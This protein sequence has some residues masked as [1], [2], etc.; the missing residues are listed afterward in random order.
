MNNKITAAYEYIRSVTDFKPQAGIILGS[1]LGEYADTL[2]NPVVIPY[3]SIP[4]FPVSTVHGHSGR[5]ILGTAFGKKIIAMQGRVHYYEGYSMNEL[6]IPVRLINMLGAKSVII[7]NAAGGVNINLPV[8][9]LMLI[10][11]HINHSGSNPLTGENLENFG[12]RF[13]DMSNIYTKSLREQ[14]K[15]SAKNVGLSLYEG[16]YMMFNGPSYE[17]PA[18]IRMAR[19]FGADA[20]GMSTVPEAISAAHANMNVI[21]ISCISNHAAGVTDTT[22]THKD[23]IDVTSRTKSDFI[24]L[25]NLILN[26]II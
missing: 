10:S 12:T 15:A 26:D 11:D 3:E 24:K 17:T 25:L 14:I 16:V 13:P 22:L 7:T 9:S 5:F 19:L 23:V 1:G 18:E 6:A 2:E 20:V 4:H 21:G 8:G